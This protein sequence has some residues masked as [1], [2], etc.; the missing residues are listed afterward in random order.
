MAT[1]IAKLV[2]F[3]GFY[4]K[5]EVEVDLPIDLYCDNKATI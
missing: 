4:K 3:T 5:L 2:W 1:T